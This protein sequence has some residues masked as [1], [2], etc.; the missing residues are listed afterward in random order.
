MCGGRKSREF[1]EKLIASTK[2]TPRDRH[3]LPQITWA[4]MSECKHEILNG[5]DLSNKVLILVMNFYL[6][7]RIR[8]KTHMS[9]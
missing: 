8:H 3:T 1:Y 5:A 2:G 7:K 4:F 9:K 6:K